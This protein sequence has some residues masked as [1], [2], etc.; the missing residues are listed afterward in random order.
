MHL[1]HVAIDVADPAAFKDW[2]VKNLGMRISSANAGF[3]TDDSGTFV[4]EV[5]RS[6][7]TAAAP[8]YKAMHPM[9]LHIAFVSDDVDKDVARLVAAGATKEELVHKPGFDMAMLRD[10]F[11]VCVQLCKRATSVFMAPR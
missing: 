5:Y 4:L 9:T 8:D 7:K 3:L 11:G 2:W 10:P 1:E 6:D